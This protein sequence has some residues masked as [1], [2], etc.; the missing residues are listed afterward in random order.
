[1][2]PED[3]DGSVKSR[4]GEDVEE[5]EAEEG[6]DVLHVVQVSP[7]HSL[8]I[9]VHPGLV[10]KQCA[11]KS[12]QVKENGEAV[13][14]TFLLTLKP[15]FSWPTMSSEEMKVPVPNLCLRTTMRTVGSIIVGDSLVMTRAALFFAK[16]NCQ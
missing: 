9:L 5:A 11:V 16:F 2:Q 12:I 1:M 14:E 3:E 7:S 8:N 15:F 10:R 6:E 13:G 4:A